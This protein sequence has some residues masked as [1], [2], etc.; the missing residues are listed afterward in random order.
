[1]TSNGTTMTACANGTPYLVT[2]GTA[3]TGPAD[4]TSLDAEAGHRL[5]V[6]TF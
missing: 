1:M 2:H 3:S 6:V 4:E 5:A